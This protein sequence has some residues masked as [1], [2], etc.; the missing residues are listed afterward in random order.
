[1][2]FLDAIDEGHNNVI[3]KFESN[4]LLISKKLEILTFKDPCLETR[5]LFGMKLLWCGHGAKLE[6]WSQIPKGMNSGCEK[7][8]KSSIQEHFFEILESL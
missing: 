3:E 4:L 6:F 2:I 1:M 8:P 5:A 7:R